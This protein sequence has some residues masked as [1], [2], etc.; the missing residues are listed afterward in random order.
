MDFIKVPI[1]LNRESR[2]NRERSRR[3]NPSL[4]NMREPFQY[5]CHCFDSSEWEGG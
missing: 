5:S 1:R 2:E 4:E 3:C